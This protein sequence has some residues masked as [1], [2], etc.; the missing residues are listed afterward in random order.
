MPEGY[1]HKNKQLGH[2]QDQRSTMTHSQECQKNRYDD[3]IWYAK[4]RANGCSNTATPQQ[5]MESHMLIPL[6]KHP[7]CRPRDPLQWLAA[8]SLSNATTIHQRRMSAEMPWSTCWRNGRPKGNPFWWK[9]CGMKLTWDIECKRRLKVAETNLD[10]VCYKYNPKQ[11]TW[12]K[13][14]LLLEHKVRDP[15]LLFE[16]NRTSLVFCVKLRNQVHAL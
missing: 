12:P 3:M 10:E 5:H 13:A 6:D 2:L 7:K 14:C 8:A 15:E 1:T 11:Q 9:S 16:E 4:E